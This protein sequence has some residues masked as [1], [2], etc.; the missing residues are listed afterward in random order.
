MALALPLAPD[1][2]P[3]GNP[4][5]YDIPTLAY[6]VLPWAEDMLAQPDG[7]RAGEPWRWTDSQA[8]I[9]LWW[10]A[11]VRGT[12][13]WVYRRGQ[14]VLPKGAGKSPFAAALSC[15]SLAGPVKFDGWDANGD[16][17]GR[18][19]PSPH[20][21]L[22]A[23]SQDQ[24]DNTMSLV[25]AML[26]EGPAADE[27]PDLDLGLTRVRTRNGKLEPVTAS[28]ASREGQRL[29]DA[30]LDEPH[31]W[32]PSNG[33][34]RLAATV[35]RN[36]G[37]MNGRSLETTN[38]WVPGGESVA[39]A[40]AEYADK[41]AEGKAVDVG[42]LRYHP[43]AEVDDLSDEDALRAGLTMLYRDSP[44]VDIDRVISEI[45]DLNTHPADARRFYLN[46]VSSADDAWLTETEWDGCKDLLHSVEPDEP[47]VLGFDG[48]KSR[49]RGVADATAL[50]AV[51]VSDGHVFPIQ[52]WEQPEGAAG[53]GWQVPKT[54]VDA[55]VREVF[56]NYNVIGF[57]ADPAK[58]ESYVATWEADFGH[59]LKVKASRE[60][61]IEWWMTGGRSGLIVRA[62]DMFYTA[63]VEKQLTHN[64]SA[65]LTRHALNARRRATRSGIQIAKEHPDSP[66]KIDAI[67]ASVLA[68][69]ARLDALAAGVGS[70]AAKKKSG[71][72]R[73]Y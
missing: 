42:L 4:A 69:T 16:A 9:V 2:L 64:G 52:V 31:L 29:T 59:R 60:H 14:V 50:I 20:V 25:L 54:E 49:S 22:C 13:K 15:C 30:I 32:T 34:V 46:Q 47:I 66:R 1:G 11:V 8:R 12:G 24:T 26:R 61:P 67:V 39:E 58:W 68:W 27:I 41:I 53:Q 6:D 56:A 5:D 57:Y 17:V 7:D 71:R 3:V 37:K 40:T 36:L 10:Y 38:T 19:H 23:V 63:V 44:W 43:K 21:Q 33:G 45:Y 18:P 48:S 55:T 51:R 35:R 65:V 72:L 28:A 62:L 73:R 70:A